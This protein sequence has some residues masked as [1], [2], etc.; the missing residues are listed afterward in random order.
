[1]SGFCL[2][3]IDSARRELGL[4]AKMKANSVRELEPS[5]RLRIFTL[6][7]SGC[8]VSGLELLLHWF[9]AQSHSWL[10]VA[11]LLMYTGRDAGSGKGSY[12][13]WPDFFIPA[14]A[15]GIVVGRVGRGWPFRAIL[16][17][18]ALASANIVALTLLYPLFFAPRSLLWMQGGYTSVG[19]LMLTLFETMLL[20]A[21]GS[22]VGTV[23]F[24]KNNGGT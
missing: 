13:P 15:L 7:A 6:I 9:I 20:V 8:I 21:V 22:V 5:M 14:L 4:S 18:I 10:G 3:G 23:A 16:L 11:L 12:Y 24:T 2:S 1:M 17:C 19:S